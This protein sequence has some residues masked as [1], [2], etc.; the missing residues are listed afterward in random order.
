MK[1]ES[2]KSLC[3]SLEVP[4]TLK[5][6]KRFEKMMRKK[7]LK[8]FTWEIDNFSEKKSPIKSTLFSSDGCEW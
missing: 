2:N 1:Q 8:S 5:L 3:P 4:K 7:L 6:R